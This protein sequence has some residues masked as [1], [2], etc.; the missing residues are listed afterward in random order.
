MKKVSTEQKFIIKNEEGLY[1]RDSDSDFTS[2]FWQNE[3]DSKVI[4]FENKKAAKQYV[5]DHH[6]I[7]EK[8][9]FDLVKEIGYE[10]IPAYERTETMIY[11]KVDT[12]IYNTCKELENKLF[13]VRGHKDTFLSLI[14]DD[15]LRHDMN[16]AAGYVSRKLDALGFEN[17]YKK[18]FEFSNLVSKI[19]YREEDGSW[20]PDSDLN[21]RLLS[22][23]ARNAACALAT[24]AD[25]LLLLEH[26]S[27]KA[28]ADK[29][30][31]I[32]FLFIDRRPRV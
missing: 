7:F 21:S 22:M 23:K 24:L 5:K 4:L 15:M 19:T 12:D 8:K 18:V 14:N 16:A 9:D 32:P 17:S 26:Y 6:R 3:L 1:L 2:A 10:I 25:G 29:T 27:D 30:K 31:T 28:N 20:R 11:E 13:N